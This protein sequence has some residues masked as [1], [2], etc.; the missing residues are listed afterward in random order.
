MTQGSARPAPKLK[1]HVIRQGVPY[2]IL[3]GAAPATVGGA[4]KNPTELVGKN[5]N[6]EI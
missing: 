5:P 1:W 3:P 6:R 2:D 4:K